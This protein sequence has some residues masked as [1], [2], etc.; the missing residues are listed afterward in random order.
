MYA[1]TNEMLAVLDAADRDP[2]MIREYARANGFTVG[3]RGRFKKELIESYVNH[4]LGTVNEPSS[5]A[6]PF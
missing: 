2:K 6:V 5:D 4:R 3:N 1:S